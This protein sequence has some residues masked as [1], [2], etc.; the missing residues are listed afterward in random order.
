MNEDDKIG[1]R[2]NSKTPN[3][4]DHQPRGSFLLFPSPS[5]WRIILSFVT[6]GQNT[7]CCH[8]SMVF[9]ATWILKRLRI[10]LS[11]SGCVSY[12]FKD[13][14][15]TVIASDFLNFPTVLATATVAN[16]K[17]RLDEA[18]VKRLLTPCG[19]G[20]PH[21]IEKTFEGIFYTVE[22]LRFLDR[23]SANVE[24][25]HHEHQRALALAA[26]IRSCLKK[27]PRGVFTVS[28]DLSH[29]DDGRRDLRL[30]IEEHFHEQVEIFNRIVFDNGRRHTV[31]RS[32]VFSLK[33]HGVDLVYLAAI[34]AASRR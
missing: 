2:S 15:K 13:M 3:A 22:D 9:C 6:W 19:S 8:G 10:L 24:K 4:R 18:A 21:F 1:A 16:D 12:L 31:K 7:G 32:D 20:G 17:Y 23:V 11:E 14:G 26:L 5:M 30:T 34:R 25:L 29:Y 33:P 28:G 27:Q